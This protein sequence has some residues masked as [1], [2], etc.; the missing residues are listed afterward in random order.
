VLFRILHAARGIAIGVWIRSAYGKYQARGAICLRHSTVLHVVGTLDA[1]TVPE[2][3]T[4][5]HQPSAMLQS[6]N[7]R[8]YREALRRLLQSF[9]LP[10]ILAFRLPSRGHGPKLMFTIWNS[11][12]FLTSTTHQ[13]RAELRRHHFFF[14]FSLFKYYFPV[15]C[16][17]RFRLQSL[18]QRLSDRRRAFRW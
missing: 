12:L 6:I 1:N 13:S 11:S 9:T 18:T 3:I 2:L 8:S 7:P 16:V 15:P 14:F 5:H 10:S 4:L 17:L